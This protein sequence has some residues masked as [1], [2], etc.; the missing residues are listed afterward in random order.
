MGEIFQIIFNSQG[1]NV[2]SNA[3]RNA[4]VYNVNWKAILGDKYKKFKCNIA[5][6]SEKVTGELY[7]VGFISMNI[8]KTNNFDGLQ[9]TNNMGIIYPY[10]YNASV[11]MSIYTCNAT[12]N[13]P[14]YIYYPTFNNVTVLLKDFNGTGDIDSMPH[15]VLML[16]LEGIE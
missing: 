6:K 8:G 10:Y 14:F 12:D 16:S 4:V 1:S 2:I 15:Y 3:S 7:D 9:Q 11:A 5:F 13:N